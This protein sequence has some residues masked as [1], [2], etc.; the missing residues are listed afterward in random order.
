MTTNRLPANERVI[1][2]RITAIMLSLLLA[3]AAASAQR[4]VTPVKPTEPGQSVV[5]PVKKEIDR[6]RLKETI[7]AQG[8]TVLVDTVTGKEFIDS[9]LLK[10][11]P[12]MEYPL[13]H[14][15]VAGV[16]LWDPAMRIFGQKYGLGDIWAEVSLHNRYFPF[17]AIGIS[18]CN[19]TPQLMNFTFKSPMAPYFKIGASYNFFYNSNPDYKL[20]MGL[21]YGFSHYKWSLTDVTVDEGY[22]QDP[23]HY[24]LPDQTSTAGYV[25]VTLGLKVK[26][27][28]PLSLGW[29]VVYHSILHE[30]AAPYGKPMYIPGYGKRSSAITANFSIIYTLPLNKRTTTEVEKEKAND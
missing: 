27:A 23:T 8:N 21:R 15:V 25:E 24:S 18:D 2:R 28:G 4:R 3:V 16:N 30:S 20:Q 6:S 13:L 12:R 17:I 11:P 19:D 22:W 10:A 14:E 9:A 29:N 26:I 7:D 1:I 5:E